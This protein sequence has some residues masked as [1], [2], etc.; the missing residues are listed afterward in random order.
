MNKLILIGN[1]TRDPEKGNS[2]N[3]VVAKFG[4]AVNEYSRGEESTMFVD[5]V[6]FGRTA[7][8]ALNYL[9]K[10]DKVALVGRLDIGSYVDRSGNRRTSVKMIAQ[11]IEQLRRV[12]ESKQRDPGAEI[13]LDDGR[14]DPFETGARFDDEEEDDSYENPFRDE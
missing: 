9:G 5:V 13:D 6:A 1:L 10:G 8:Y 3:I 2:E 7:E 11:E 12:S 14:Y 4:I